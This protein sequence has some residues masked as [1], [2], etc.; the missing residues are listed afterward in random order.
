MQTGLHGLL[1]QVRREH[2]ERTALV[3]DGVSRS[4]AEFAARV[5]AAATCGRLAG[6]SQCARVAVL[7]PNTAAFLEAYF[8]LAGLG[9]ICVPLNT[10]LAPSELGWILGDCEAVGLI[11]DTRLAQTADGALACASSSP[12]VVWCGPRAEGRRPHWDDWCTSDAAVWAPAAC[13]RDAPAQLYYTSGTTGSPKGVVLTHG[14]VLTHAASAVLELGLTRDDVW[15]HFAPLFH[16]ADA[17]ATFA[18][19]QVG[20]RH[21]CVP[22]FEV[23][24]VLEAFERERVTI[25]NLVPTMLNRLV[26]AKGVEQRDFSSLR[27]VLSGGAPIAPELVRRIMH[28]FRA[29]YVQTYGMTETSPYLTLSLLSE[30]HSGLSEEERFRLR[31]KTGRPFH[32]VELRVVDEAGANVPADG[33]SVGEI[34]ARGATVTP[35]YWRRPDATAAAFTLD[36]YLRT[37][38]L[39]TLDAWG[40]LDI[41]ERKKDVILTGGEKVYSTEVEH[42]LVEHPAVLEVA[43]WGEPDA[44]WGERVR[45]SVVLR[46]GRD[47]TPEE[48]AAFCR[49]RLAGF[50]VPRSFEF[51]PEL[52]RTGSG[53]IS[54]RALRDR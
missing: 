3:E 46:P 53:K 27:R 38:D 39:A 17:W 52:P 29:E 36:G 20:G 30:A 23:E 50:K 11:A 22:W 18:I 9:A 25:T 41:V 35:G 44:D 43:V 32:G 4:Y 40:F 37:G 48:L 7:A 24:A 33:A 19:T 42:R 15:G 54:K 1:S 10:R 21:V 5:D 6:W 12:A 45:A 51:L 49:E 8:A 16:L 34:L 31:A 26:N 14:N 47:A 28:T 13:A 2:A